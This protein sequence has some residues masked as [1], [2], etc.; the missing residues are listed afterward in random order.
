MALVRRREE[1]PELEFHLARIQV[2]E[3]IKFPIIEVHIS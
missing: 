3:N 2:G 1:V